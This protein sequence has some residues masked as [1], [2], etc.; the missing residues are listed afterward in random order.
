MA[1][2]AEPIMVVYQDGV[3]RPRQPLALRENQLIQILVLNEDA[4]APSEDERLLTLERTLAAWLESKL[5][6]IQTLQTVTAEQRTALDKE[7]DQ[8]LDA[9]R[10]HTRLDSEQVID[11]IV[12]EAL[13]AVRHSGK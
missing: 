8:L 13:N 4:L 7:F 2:P 5:V 11:G 9:L 6:A 1:N 10:H 3:L 12:D